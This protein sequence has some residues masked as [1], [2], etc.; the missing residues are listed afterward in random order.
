MFI[1]LG[2][3]SMNGAHLQ[4]YG[5]RLV[6][7]GRLLG[8]LAAWCVI[9]Q[10]IL[11]SRVPFIERN[12]DLQDNIQLHKYNGYAL[13]ATISGHVIFL[14][15][16]YALPMH[17]TLWNQTIMF[18]TQYSDVFLATVGTTIFFVASFLSLQALR[19]KMR[20][21]IWYLLHLT[22]YLGIF[23]T[24]LH[25]IKTGGDFIN[26]FWF[27][28]YWYALYILAFVVWLRYR[29]I[30][31]LL[32]DFKH[33]FQVQSVVKTAANTYSVTLTGEHIRDFQFEPGQY[34]TWR[35]LSGNLWYEAHPFSISSPRGADYLQFTVKA[36]PTLTAKIANV[37]QGTYVIVDGPRGSF[38]AERAE[39]TSKVVLI[40]GGIGVAPYLSTIEDLLNNGKDVTLL[41]SA[42]T[43]ADVAFRNELRGLQKHGLKISLY[44]NEMNQKITPEVLG[45][46]SQDD[47]TIYICGPDGMSLSFVSTLQSLGFAQRNII[48]ERFAF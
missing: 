40:A 39:K 29:V 9:I 3:W 4:T 5:D 27:T 2:W 21:E 43:D 17:V 41:Y 6:T 30:N 37:R 1:M 34:A 33:G 14:T 11:M 23:F 25:Q 31:P 38:T 8:L 44:L 45:S 18:N 22:V 7:I 24:F 20:Y 15:L 35:F 26:N 36:S 16:G 42:R 13:L 28:A 47:T 48:T 32:L 12:F 46:I 10:I 19:A